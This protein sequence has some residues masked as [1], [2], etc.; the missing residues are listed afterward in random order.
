MRRFQTLSTRV[1]QLI[2]DLLLAHVAVAVTQLVPVITASC[3]GLLFTL[4]VQAH[5]AG[6]ESVS[7][8]REVAFDSEVVAHILV[9]AERQATVACRLVAVVAAAVDEVGAERL[10]VA[11]RRAGTVGQEVA[12]IHTLAVKVVAVHTPAA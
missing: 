2:A 7:A 4:V 5:V 1:L 12:G 9:F 10:A 3:T 11:P 6:C 8:R